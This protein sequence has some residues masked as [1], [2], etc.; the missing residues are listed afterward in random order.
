[1]VKQRG[2][3]GSQPPKPALFL[4]AFSL[5]RA[6]AIH[7]CHVGASSIG[8]SKP[9]GPSQPPLADPHPEGPSHSEHCPHAGAHVDCSPG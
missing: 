2:A 7:L 8:G 3:M 5:Q 1:M 6:L 9:V 4:Q